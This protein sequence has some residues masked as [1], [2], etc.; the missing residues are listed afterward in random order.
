MTSGA[1]WLSAFPIQPATEAVEALQEAW[2]ILA[3]KP[4]A[5]FNPKTKEPV[6]T[7]TLKMYVENVTARERGLLGMWAAENV[8]GDFDPETGK[9][10]EE[11]RTDIVYGWN[12]E[13]Q[14]IQLVFEFKRLGKQ[15]SHRTHYLG[16]NGLGRFV[17]G[18]YSRR[19]SVAAMVGILLDPEHEVVPL[20]RK[21][22]EGADLATELRL[23]PTTAGAPL[24][25]PSSLFRT[26]DFDTEHERDADLAP[27]HGHIR[28]SHFFLQ[29]GYPTST[30]KAKA[31]TL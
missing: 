1:D 24:Q 18:I 30:T 6:L 11:R 2:C 4:R 16:K 5:D 14:S 9:I 8:I 15:K 20:L 31:T 21:A 3:E 27:T 26:A 17:S 12:N 7:K 19:Q 23:R 22:F 28:V 25:R 29:F 13:S 10:L